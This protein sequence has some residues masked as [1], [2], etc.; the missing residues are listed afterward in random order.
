MNL[1]LTLCAGIAFRSIN[2]FECITS[3]IIGSILIFVAFFSTLFN[4]RFI[5]WSCYHRKNRSRYN[6]FILSMIFSSI[7]LTIIIVPSVILQCLRCYRL[8]SLVYCQLEGFISYLNGCVHMFMLMMISVIRYDTILHRNTTK[9]YLQRHSYIV[10]SLCWLFG[11]IFALPPLFHWNK[12]TPEGLGFH[13]GLN[14]FD[15]SLISHVYLF[16]TFLFVYFIPLIVLSVVNIYVYGVIRRLLYK[17]ATVVQLPFIELL[18]PDHLSVEK[19]PLTA[20]I[21]SHSSKMHS[22]KLEIVQ[23]SKSIYVNNRLRNRCM[24]DPAQMH[25]IMR[26][27][28]LKA[29]QCFAL[30][31][32]FLVSEYLLSWTPYACVALFYLFHIKF[33]I[34]QPLLITICAFIAK[35]SMIINPFIYILTTKTNQLKT[36]LFCK[37]CSCFNCRVQ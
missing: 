19:H 36:I 13:C 8:C 28:R 6:F 26:L 25:H 21:S 10:V 1:N 20:L 16:F 4:I 2:N 14:W 32:I 27:N 33:I 15:R 5:Y 31:T 37:T 9:I 12:Y 18:H 34:E 29:D 30:A 17:V 22:N 24:T 23:L 3:R 35:I 7:S 11:L